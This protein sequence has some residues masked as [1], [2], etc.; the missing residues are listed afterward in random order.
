MKIKLILGIFLYI[1]YTFF[2]YPFD[3]FAGNATAA[4]CSAADIQTAINTVA[5]G[6]GGIVTLPT[7]D[8][9]WG[10]GDRI[11]IDSD[12]DLYFRGAGSSL[13]KIKYATGT[14]PGSANVTCPVNG[15]MNQSNYSIFVQGAG[16]REVSGFTF[17]GNTGGATVVNGI[18]VRQCGGSSDAERR[19]CQTDTNT[20]QR[21]TDII[22]EGLSA[23]ERGIYL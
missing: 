21:F 8:V 9:E 19:A 18:T 20:S 1:L 16:V 23:D 4:S 22:I 12:D 6:G 2:W 14:S 13:T 11:C 17:D 7:C 3:A 15:T 5:N 10:N